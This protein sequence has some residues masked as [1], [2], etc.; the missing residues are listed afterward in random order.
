MGIRE[1]INGILAGLQFGNP[2]IE[3]QI[4]DYLAVVE[5]DP[6]WKDALIQGYAVAGGGHMAYVAWAMTPTMFGG[7][8]REYVA[9]LR[10]VEKGKDGWVVCPPNPCREAE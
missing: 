10:V 5:H 8:E 1:E 6:V 3:E 4:K 9:Q 2:S 7:R